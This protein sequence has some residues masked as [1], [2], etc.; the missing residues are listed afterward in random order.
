M[1]CFT[2]SGAEST[3]CTPS[4][5]KTTACLQMSDL[6]DS[7]SAAMNQRTLL[8]LMLQV[9]AVFIL[10]VMHGLGTMANTWGEGNGDT[11]SIGSSRNDDPKASCHFHDVGQKCGRLTFGQ[12]SVGTLQHPRLVR[13]QMSLFAPVSS[14]R[15]LPHSRMTLQRLRTRVQ[16]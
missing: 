7:Q 8:I 15:A 12:L 13:Q 11:S 14:T 9:F 16:V 1:E 5:L 10:S 6:R 3:L 2:N 4:G